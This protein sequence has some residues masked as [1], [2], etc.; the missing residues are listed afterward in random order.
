MMAAMMNPEIA[1][2]NLLPDG[3]PVKLNFPQLAEIA[4]EAFAALSS[5][6]V[7]VSLGDGAEAI[8]ADMLVADSAEPAPFFSM[9]MDWARYYSMLGE[10]ISRA[11][12]G[13]V[14]NEM[15]QALRGAVRDVM[16]LIGSMYE[17]LSVDVQFTKRGIEI[18]GRMKLSD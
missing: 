8:S 16:V 7:A 18:N 6:A 10:A 17:R 14:E 3:K 11:P 5:S 2:L 13:D 1:A 15:P 9:N 12:S 4:D